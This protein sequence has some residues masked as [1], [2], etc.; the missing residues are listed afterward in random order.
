M[1]DLTRKKK[2]IPKVKQKEKE[3][4]QIRIQ[5]K[6]EEEEKRIQRQQEILARHQDNPNFFRWG[7]K[8]YPVKT[9][10]HVPIGVVMNDR[11]A[12]HEV[13]RALFY[14]KLI[15]GYDKQKF[16]EDQAAG[17]MLFNRRIGEVFKY[18][19]SSPVEG[20]K[21][22][23]CESSRWNNPQHRFNMMYDP[24]LTIFPP[25]RFFHPYNPTLIDEFAT[26]EA[27]RKYDLT[28][29]EERNFIQI[30]NIFDTVLNPQEGK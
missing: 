17:R 16:F 19:C 5:K 2:E 15:F 27:R 1:A 13:Q 7:N 10:Q 4:E 28:H 3:E 20:L 24:K 22:T 23:Y 25:F 29:V 21:I 12:K 18:L 14:N 8:E 26:L 11:M 9:K 6:K 30:L